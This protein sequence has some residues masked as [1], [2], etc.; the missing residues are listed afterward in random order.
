L[1]YVTTRNDQDTFTTNHVLTQNRGTDGGLFVPLNFPKIS[2]QEWKKL[3]E[4]SFGQCVAEIL[5]LFFSTKL[6]GWDVDF[7]IGRYPARLE[8]L[9]HRIFMAETWHNPQWQY[10]RIEKNLMELLSSEVNIPGNWVSIAIR[11]AVLAGI[12]G[13]REISDMVPTDIAVVTGDFTL[14]I[15]AWYLRKMG[16]PIG[17]IICCCNENNQFWELF[18]NGQMR[19]DVTRISTIVPEA[20]VIM[21]VNLER[22][23]SDC[24]TIAETERYLSCNKTGTTYSVSDGMLQ[25]LRRELFVSVV[26]SVR[27]ETTIPNVYK[28]HNYI[29]SPASALAYSGL[30]DYRAKTG[31]TRNAIVICDQSPVCDAETVARVMDIPLAKLQKL[32]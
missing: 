27:I 7:S 18:C 12:L 1:L 30:L 28:T 31:I 26:S 10:Q 3:S 24:S 11:M 14:P 25:L 4:M 32:I 21:P 29:L 16:F 13:H 5:N 17:N 20:D 22:L 2:A 6:T 23:I 19:T 8:Q 9:A 15:S